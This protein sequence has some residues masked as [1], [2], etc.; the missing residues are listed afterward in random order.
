MTLTLYESMI[1]L[2]LRPP[3]SKKFHLS[4]FSYLP[5]NSLNRVPKKEIHQMKSSS[6]KKESRADW[7]AVESEFQ[8]AGEAGKIAKAKSAFQYYQKEL[9]PAIRE[10]MKSVVV[11]QSTTNADGEVVEVES[12]PSYDL[13]ACQKELSLRVS[14]FIPRHQHPYFRFIL[15]FI[16]LIFIT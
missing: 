14:I 12:T 15:I 9:L 3:K 6:K 8:D 16:I 4:N 2:H 1:R 11:K 5:Y 10:E 13:G 7:V